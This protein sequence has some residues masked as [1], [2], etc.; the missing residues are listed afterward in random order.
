MKKENKKEFKLN[1]RKLT[2]IL[3]LL[4]FFISWAFLFGFLGYK[5]G[6]L[7]MPFLEGFL[8]FVITGFLSFFVSLVLTLICFIVIIKLTELVIWLYTED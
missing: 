8:I 6:V 5:Q 4:N 2:D 3:L 7:D 1:Q